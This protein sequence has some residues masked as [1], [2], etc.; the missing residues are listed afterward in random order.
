MIVVARIFGFVVLGLFL[1][2]MILWF[3]RAD[4]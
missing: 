3:A 1:V 2:A 4:E